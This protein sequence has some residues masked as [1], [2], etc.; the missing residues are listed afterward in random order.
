M[1]LSV[2][3][4]K[5][6]KLQKCPLYCVQNTEHSDSF[7]KPRIYY[8]KWPKVTTTRKS[9]NSMKCLPNTEMLGHS[10]TIDVYSNRRYLTLSN[11]HSYNGCFINVQLKRKEESVKGNSDKPAHKIYKDAVTE[12][13]SVTDKLRNILIRQV[14]Y[15]REKARTEEWPTKDA[16]TNLHAMAYEEEG[17]IHYIAI[18]EEY[19]DAS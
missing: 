4:R 5:L 19:A 3:H 13:Q 1:D 8:G 14:H 17:F 10:W 18:Y 2:N 6:R 11:F 12:G 7:D 9:M 16:I 15:I